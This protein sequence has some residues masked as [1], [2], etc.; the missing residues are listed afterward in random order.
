MSCL[1][2]VSLLEFF[3]DELYKRNE[4]ESLK[5]HN[6]KSCRPTRTF[7]K[8]KMVR[9]R[10]W[11]IHIWINFL[12]IISG[13]TASLKYKVDNKFPINVL[14][15]SLVNRWCPNRQQSF[16]DLEVHGVGLVTVEENAFQ[17]SSHLVRISLYNNEIKSIP[18]NT[19]KNLK[20]L[21]LLELGRNR[22]EK[23]DLKWFQDLKELQE[24]HLQENFITF[25]S[26]EIC[27][28]L[29]KLNSLVLYINELS[30]I[31]TSEVKEYCKSK[32]RIYIHDNP[33]KCSMI[34]ELEQNTF[35]TL[36][37]G[38]P[39]SEGEERAMIK[40][41]QPKF[42][43]YDENEKI[44]TKNFD[45]SIDIFFTNPQKKLN[46]K[47]TN[48]IIK[49]TTNYVTLITVSSIIIL[50]NGVFMVYLAVISYQSG[51]FQ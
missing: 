21:E 13:V 20:K 24:L 9:K 12:F 43:C 38:S 15:S 30:H 25:V 29:P 46:E 18:S 7:F 19:F 36:E 42:R 32:I 35:V 4:F 49:K 16:N 40:Y 41:K 31:N 11:L 45:D 51:V 22:L 2:S 47:H 17:Y 3:P 28:M 48:I 27:Q 5:Q 1:E 34:N 6:F 33:L 23:I 26:F 14:S 50:I 37:Y 44:E 39:S 10:N 8:K